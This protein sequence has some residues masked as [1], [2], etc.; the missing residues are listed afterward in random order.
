MLCTR[1]ISLTKTW[2]QNDNRRTDGWWDSACPQSDCVCYIV[3]GADT[4]RLLI[5]TL[6][7]V[8]RPEEKERGVC[9][10]MQTVCVCVCE[11][12][13]CACL[14]CDKCLKGAHLCAYV[15]ACVNTCDGCWCVCVCV[16]VCTLLCARR[17]TCAAEMKGKSPI[18][19]GVMTVLFGG[20]KG[21]GAGAAGTSPG[22]LLAFLLSPSDRCVNSIISK[23]PE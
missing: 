1:Q 4:C 23:D 11:V 9:K 8:I 20:R 19:C 5:L 12:H 2:K 21:F 16:C 14:V 6:Y 13:V 22:D 7:M 3:V 18:C 17:F 15:C 10:W